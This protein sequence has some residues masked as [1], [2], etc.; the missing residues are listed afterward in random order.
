MCVMG[1]LSTYNVSKI[2][3]DAANPNRS[4]NSQINSMG[5]SSMREQLFWSPG[6]SA[7]PLV[8]QGRCL[9]G[10]LLIL[11]L[12]RQGFVSLR[13]VDYLG[14]QLLAQRRQRALP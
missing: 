8:G 3:C 2:C 9:G 13:V 5:F 1:S 6:S 12:G 10:E 11:R 7:V 14:Q 4:T